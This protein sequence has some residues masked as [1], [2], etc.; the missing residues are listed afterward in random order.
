MKWEI[1]YRFVDEN[2][3]KTMTVDLKFTRKCDV[4]KWFKISKNGFTGK[5]NIEFVNAELI[6]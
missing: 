5:R 3:F 2:K 1:T 4:G 6:N